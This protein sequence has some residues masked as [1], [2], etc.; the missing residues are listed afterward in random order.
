MRIIIA[1][2]LENYPKFGTESWGYGKENIKSIKT[3][4]QLNIQGVY[5]KRTDNGKKAVFKNYFR[6]GKGIDH[7][8]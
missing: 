3:M 2:S 6:T 7:K 5:K 4:Y 1:Q 8:I